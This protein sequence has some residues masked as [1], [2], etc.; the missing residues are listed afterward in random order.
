MDA[1]SLSVLLLGVQH[2]IVVGGVVFVAHQ[3]IA[4]L[5]EV[6]DVNRHD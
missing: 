6:T 5:L 2:G 1:N 3:V 4:L